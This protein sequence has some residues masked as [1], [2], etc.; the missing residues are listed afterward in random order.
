MQDYNLGG[1]LSCL[2]CESIIINEINIY[3]K[4][5]LLRTRVGKVI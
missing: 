5:P 3:F 1:K 4:K 2:N